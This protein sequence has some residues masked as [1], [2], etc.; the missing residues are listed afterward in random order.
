M[1]ASKKTER[2]KT[3]PAA[4]GEE[5]APSAAERGLLQVAIPIETH[6]RAKAI[7]KVRKV[8]L[9]EYIDKAVLPVIERDEKEI[10]EQLKEWSGRNGFRH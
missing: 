4:N 7:A 6:G 3:N 1:N 10:A 2:T 8:S 5:L 9:G